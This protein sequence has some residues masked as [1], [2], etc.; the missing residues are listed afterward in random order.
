MAWH[1]SHI[2]FV[3]NPRYVYLCVHSLFYPFFLLWVFETMMLTREDYS[4]DISH[5]LK[6]MRAQEVSHTSRPRDSGEGG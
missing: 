6:R 3:L 1:H 5:R 2:F 4:F